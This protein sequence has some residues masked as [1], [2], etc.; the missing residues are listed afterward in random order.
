MHMQ[1]HEKDVSV[2]KEFWRAFVSTKRLRK[3]SDKTISK[4]GAEHSELLAGK[5][6]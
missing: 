5:D 2:R 1:T 6:S 3:S 4:H